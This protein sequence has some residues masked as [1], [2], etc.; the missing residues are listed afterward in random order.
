MDIEN[1]LNTI[2][3]TLEAKMESTGTEKICQVVLKSPARGAAEC[4]RAQR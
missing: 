3:E 2:E 1:L 4:N